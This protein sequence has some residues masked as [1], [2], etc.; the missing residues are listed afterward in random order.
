M[1]FRRLLG[2]L[3]SFICGTV[4]GLLI[5]SWFVEMLP[6]PTVTA[7]LQGMR[8]TGGTAEGCTFYVLQFHTVQQLE[9]V[10][11]RVQFPKRIINYKVGWPQDAQT[12]TGH[13]RSAQS[14][15]LAQNATGQCSV[16]GAGT[17]NTV[18]IQIAASGNMISISSSKLSPKSSIMGVVATSETQSS[19]NPA[20]RLY[21]EG[22]YEYT[23]LGSIVRKQLTIQD[24]G[25]TETK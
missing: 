4:F 20:P 14:W 25:I 7:I 5:N 21:T 6:G 13:R 17:D 3:A 18:D 8:A 19:I 24:K 9:Y 22:A 10:Y 12:V 23:K 15:R 1:P 2:G 16:E 11:L